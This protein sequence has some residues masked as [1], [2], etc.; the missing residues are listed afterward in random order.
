VDAPNPGGG[1]EGAASF[2]V[3]AAPPANFAVQS[4]YVTSISWVWNATA[5]FGSAG[6][7]SRDY[8]I[9]PAT[10]TAPFPGPEES[11]GLLTGAT[12]E[13]LA[14][15][16]TY[17]RFVTAYTD[18]GYS[19][20][21]N[22][23]STHT[24]AQA[25]TA[26]GAPFTDVSA[27]G[28][29]VN[30]N[31]GNNPGYTAY[32]IDRSTVE[33]LASAVSTS[34]GAGV[35]SSPAA[36]SPNTTY[37]FKIRAINADQIPTA[38]TQVLATAT[39]AA[40]PAQ[41]AFGSVH[42]T[43]VAFQWSPAGNPSDTL[44]VAEV[45]SDNFFSLI[46]GSATLSASA[47]FFNLA[48]GAQYFFRVKALNR[49]AIATA[50]TVSIST[51]SGILSDV[52]APAAPGA[53]RSDRAFSY[54]GT[55]VF[56]WSAAQSPVG[57]LDYN[58]ILGSSP[59][60]N[61]LFNGSTTT[62]SYQAAGMATGRTY[63]ARVRARSNSGV[64]SE[65]SDVSQGLPVFLTNQAAA[66]PKPMNW[67]NPFNPAQGPTQIAVFLEAPATVV[68]RFY[69]L[70]GRLLREISR[71]LSAGG[72]QIIEWD[73]ADGSGSRVAPGGYVVRIEKRYGGRVEIQKLKI[74]VLY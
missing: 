53:P 27:F 2:G 17:Y 21:S 72:N 16:T 49:A 58:L 67:P 44:Y 47:T 70:E 19:L 31:G 15:N 42:V 26:A 63:Y 7:G 48:P 20:P 60:G 6:A 57:I 12:T 22:A 24:L 33:G 37:Y 46:A 29:S 55:A 36:L 45:S 10:V 35:S 40:Q 4:V 28:L 1:S 73:G 38:Y 34:Y 13:N 25:P 68:L 23:V 54:D 51:K 30:W 61:D 14:P 74:A 52:T 18:W 11:A 41:A 64:Y 65:F 5:D 59:G 9:F 69:S 66:L 71:Q 32:Q 62:L 43:S 56:S 39:L 8:R 3:I 50:P